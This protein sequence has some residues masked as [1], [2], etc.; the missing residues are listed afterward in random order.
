MLDTHAMAYALYNAKQ[1]LDT[2][3]TYARFLFVEFS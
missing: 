1:H 3:N 2:P